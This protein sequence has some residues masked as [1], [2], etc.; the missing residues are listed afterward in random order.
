MKQIIFMIAALMALIGGVTAQRLNKPSKPE[1]IALSQI[2]LP[3]IKGQQHSLSQWQGKKLVIN[4]WATWCPPCLKEIPD[5]MAVQNAYADKNV[6]FIGIAIDNLAAV[7][8]YH[9][10]MN[11][12]YPILI[13]EQTGIQIARS[14]GNSIDSIP[15]TVVLNPAGQIIHRHMGALSKSQL[16][17]FLN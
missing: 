2:T 15:F 1:T 4:F 14:W 6:Q 5:F 8:E 13:A 12:N 17:T 10:K 11:I 7:T 16:L 9:A 3:D